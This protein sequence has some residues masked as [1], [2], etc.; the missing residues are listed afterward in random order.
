VE[1][2]RH[3]WLARQLILACGGPLAA[4]QYCRLEKSRLSECQNPGGGAFLPVDVIA[5]LEAYCGEPIYSRALFEA[6]PGGPVAEE[7]LEEACEAV[8]LAAGLQTLVRKL[9]ARPLAR[10]DRD[11]VM[12]TCGQIEVRVRALMAHCDQVAS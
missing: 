8:E 1:A 12:A 10:A 6:R 3:A 4:A 2:N 9:P 11:N 5:D 7:L